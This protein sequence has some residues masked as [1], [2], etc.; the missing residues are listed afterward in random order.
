[1]VVRPVSS[2]LPT[3]VQICSRIPT[4]VELIPFTDPLSSL[5]ARIDNDG[6]QVY[7]RLLISP[8]FGAPAVPPAMSISDYFFEQVMADFLRSG[9]RRV[10][11]Y[12]GTILEL[13][14]EKVVMLASSFLRWKL[15]GL[16]QPAT[17]LTAISSNVRILR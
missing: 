11:R 4:G 5:Q 8:N 6:S 16:G 13:D 2:V 3:E 7:L 9:Y 17:S 12:R 14:V 10:Q 15:L 1:M